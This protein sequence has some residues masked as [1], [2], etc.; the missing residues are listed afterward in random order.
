MVTVPYA[1]GFSQPL[2]A[3]YR[4]EFAS[5]AEEA[6][7][8]GHNKIDALYSTVPVCKVSEVELLQLG[9]SPSIFDNVNTPED[10]NRMQRRLGATHG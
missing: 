5:V 8:A 6:L 10:W 7:K 1:G 9:F 4:E 2:C 3:V